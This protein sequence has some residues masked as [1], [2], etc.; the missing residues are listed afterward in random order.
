M[1]NGNERAY[2]NQDANVN[3][4]FRYSFLLGLPVLRQQLLSIRENLF[5]WLPFDVQCGDLGI[6]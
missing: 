4:Y 2:L 5:D 1:S 3:L 6:G